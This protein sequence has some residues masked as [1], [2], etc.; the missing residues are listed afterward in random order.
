M[1]PTTEHIVDLYHRRRKTHQ[2]RLTAMNTLRDAYEGQ[3]DLPLPELARNEKP[4]VANLIAQG[5]DGRANRVS[6]TMPNVTCPPLR[7]GFEKHEENANDRRNA[8]M[9][10]WDENGINLSMRKRARWLIGYGSAPVMIGF[11]LSRKIPIW[12]E[13]SPLQCLPPP[14]D[15]L[16]PVNMIFTYRKSLQWLRWI[17]PDAAAQLDIGGRPDEVSPDTEFTI[18]R[19][20]DYEVITEV[21]LGQ[22]PSAGDRQ[23]WTPPVRTPRPG[24]PF[25]LLQQLRNYTGLPLVVNPCRITLEGAIGEF[26]GVIGLYWNQAMLMA[27]EAIAVKRSIF[28]D[29]WKMARPNETVQTIV[30]A[31][32]LS[33]IVGEISGGVIQDLALQPG[34]QTYPTLDR[35]ERA[36]RLSAGIPAEMTGESAS[37]I[38]TARRGAQV[39][40]SSVDFAVQEY[41]EIFERSMEAELV[42]AIAVDKAYFKGQTKSY[43]MSWKGERGWG[44][45]VPEDLWVT[46]QVRVRY[47]FPGTD[48]N[49]L[50][51]GIGQRL[52]M[53]TISHYR[54]MELDPL[55]EDPDLER[56]RIEAESLTRAFEQGIMTQISQGQ[57]PADDAAYVVQQKLEKRVPL[58]EAVHRAQQRAQARQASQPSPGPDA[59]AQPQALPPGAPEAQP[60]L[61][62]GPGGAAAASIQGPSP[63]AVNL[64]QLLGNLRRTSQ[65]VG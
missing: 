40:S 4:L 50:I 54:A 22:A 47:A 14:G 46:D 57:I 13:L 55:I 48:L 45:Y 49:E 16:C 38:R 43:Y 5:L 60:G 11:D 37:N 44:E 3:M 6:S 39:M 7:P 35:L 30:E 52:G 28:P 25:V 26:D 20:T 31:D 56:D 23:I 36:I 10:W 18:I 29:R 51:V 42:R 27:L 24:R 65:P 9:G 41:Q 64:Q 1:P 19:Y 15:D 62:A 53:E 59:G 21:V 32:G 33:G 61:A 63:D 17:Y 12:I 58:F 8:V 34:V 2:G